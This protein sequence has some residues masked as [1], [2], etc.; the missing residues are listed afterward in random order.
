M[1]HRHVALQQL[2]A[3]PLGREVADP[4]VRAALDGLV[5]GAHR[6]P[7]GGEPLRLAHREGVRRPRL[8]DRRSRIDG[9]GLVAAEETPVERQQQRDRDQQHQQRD[10]HVL[11]RPLGLGRRRCHPR[12]RRGPLTGPRG[13]GGPACGV[14]RHRPG[15]RRLPHRLRRGLTSSQ[16]RL[17]SDRGGRTGSRRRL[18][19]DKGRLTDGRRRRAG[20]GGLGADGVVDRRLAVGRRAVGG[21]AIGRLCGIH[22]V[23]FAAARPAVSGPSPP[24]A[25]ARSA[26]V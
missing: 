18:T 2:D 11:G 21:Y 14:T 10:R 13:G 12:R 9:G 5:A 24:R 17:T 15:R 25:D 22:P 19:G 3:S 8:L 1:L 7:A 23:I 4:Q 20:G 26:I 6:T 16:G